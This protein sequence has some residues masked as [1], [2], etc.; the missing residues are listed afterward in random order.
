[1][2]NLSAKDIHRHR[3]IA[4]GGIK[5]Y[6]MMLIIMMQ[7][8]LIPRSAICCSNVCLLFFPSIKLLCWCFYFHQA[9][10]ILES[11]FI[12]LKYN[13]LCDAYGFYKT[14]SLS[15]IFWQFNIFRRRNI[16]NQYFSIPLKGKI[17]TYLFHL[18]KAQNV[19]EREN[20]NY[21]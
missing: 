6:Y 2:V 12:F 17:F 10:Y 9:E 3:H 1:M 11:H 19:I 21:W 16:F 14:K 20:E 5:E 7:Y 15:L 18:W 4:L 8:S 13:I